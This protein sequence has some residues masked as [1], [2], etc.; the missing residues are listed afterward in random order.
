MKLHRATMP[1][2]GQ[3]VFSLTLVFTLATAVCLADDTG[4]RQPGVRVWYVGV[5]ASYSGQSDAE[6]ANLIEPAAGTGLRVVRHSA[7][8]FWDAPLP[9]SILAA[10]NPSSEGPFWISP[11]RLRT[12]HP[13]D[14]FSWQGLNLIV[15]ARVTYQ[16]AD[17]LP[18]IAYLPVQ[19]LYA[20]QSP[21]ELITLTGENDGVAG[22]YFFDVETGL[23]LS[24]TLNNPGFYM[25][26]MMSEINYDFAT[27]QAFA[28]DNGPHSAYRMGQ[29][30][31]RMAWPINQ[32]YLFEERVLSRYGQSVRGE[33][34]LSIDNIETGQYFHGDYYSLFDGANRQ[35]LI[36]PITGLA[37]ATPAWTVNGTHG[38]YWVPVGDLARDAI[39]VWNLDLTHRDAGV[40]ATDQPPGDWGFTRLEFDADGFVREMRVQSTSMG[41][42]LDSST[43]STTNYLTG[44][45]YYSQVMSNAIPTGGGGAQH[46]LGIMKMKVPKKITLNGTPVTKT[47]TVTLQNHSTQPETITNGMLHLEVISLGACAKPVPKTVSP[48]FPVTLAPKAKLNVVFSVT[49]G[50]ANDPLVTSKTATHWDYRYLAELQTADSDAHDDA[51]PHDMPLGGVDPINGKVKD[52]GCGGKKPDKT[53]GADMFTD[54]VVK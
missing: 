52:K 27:H 35:F 5:T 38:F 28:E 50:C 9:V 53:L 26:M 4:W 49:Y 22:D 23:G 15:K 42:D 12:L 46:D 31:G 33:L 54:M 21:R 10:P 19:A 37:T 7:V 13:P 45:A 30:A 39:R 43:A 40:F 34:T 2:P 3:L 1:R 25:M 41:I 17:D 20:A 14:T 8:G 29:G 48:T 36:A 32:Y 44:R 24:S 51:C 11:V 6:E 16:N 47:V 18:F